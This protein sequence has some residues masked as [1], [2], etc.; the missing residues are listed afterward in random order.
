MEYSRPTPPEDAPA[1]I[2]TDLDNLSPEQLLALSQ[3]ADEL[4]E[5]KRREERLTDEETENESDSKANPD[6]V[7]SNATLTVKEINDN[8]YEYWQWREGEDIK[9][10]YKCPVESDE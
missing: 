3:Y 2:L 4:A 7:P 6:D 5:Y 10:K 9:S 1:D 8:R